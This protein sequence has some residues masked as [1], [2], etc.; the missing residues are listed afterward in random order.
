MSEGLQSNL[1][2]FADDN[3]LYVTSDSHEE[4]ANILNRD[5]KTIQRWAKQWLITFNPG[6]THNMLVS[7]N[8][9]PPAYPLFM[10]NQPLDTVTESLHLG[11]TLQH[12]LKW[13]RHIENICIKA[14]KRLD[15]LNS[16]SFKLSRRTLDILYKAYVRS[17]LEYADILFCNTTQDNLDKLDKV[18][19]RAGKIVSGAI[20]GT[21]SE[22]IYH[23]LSWE[24]L[25]TRREKRK[26]LLYSDIMHNRAPPYLQEHIPQTVQERTHGRYN[27]RTNRN[28]SQPAARTET[29]KKS[30]FPTMVTTWNNSDPTLTSIPSRTTLRNTLDHDIP[31]HN[32]Y[33]N[34]GRRKFNI[35]MARMRM[36]CSDLNSH[37]FH[38]H[39][40]P[41]PECRCGGLETTTHYL[42]DCP[43]FTVHRTELSNKLRLLNINLT[44]QTILHGTSDP[45]L[46]HRLIALVDEFVTATNRFQLLDI[47]YNR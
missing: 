16:L 8:N 22:T 36:E 6:K 12:N 3:L 24:S 28:L 29:F 25:D 45:E 20:R 23:E 10:H 40:I 46:D 26:L 27:L 2:L 4:N 31:K 38:Y 33:F 7:F 14:H 30:Y 39:V 32:P 1:S 41:S 44:V 13:D 47:D 21:S 37:L 35:V 9:E 17:I 34:F 42:L 19:K 5:I 43:L 18:H 11:V 15:I